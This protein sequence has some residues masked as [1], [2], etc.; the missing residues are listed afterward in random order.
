MAPY[1]LTN[2]ATALS[3]KPSIFEGWSTP[4]L[5]LVMTHRVKIL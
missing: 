1:F 3:Q 4:Y 2:V 5:P